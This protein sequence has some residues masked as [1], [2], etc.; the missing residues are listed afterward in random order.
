MLTCPKVYIILVNYK[1]W[2]D[3]AEC[4]ESL[5][6]LDYQNFKVIVVDNDS[7]NG[8]FAQ[9]RSWAAGDSPV[10]FNEQFYAA[11]PVASYPI[12]KPVP[13]LH[14]DSE[15]INGAA[16]ADEK[17]LLVESRKN[18]GFAGGNN[19]GCRLALAHQA[20]YVW[21]LNN[22]TVVEKESLTHLVAHF[23]KSKYNR[24]R[25]GILGAKLLYYHN[26]NFVQAILGKYKPLTASTTHIGLNRPASTPFHDLRI[27]ADDYVVGASMFVSAD[28]VKEVGFMCEEY[29][30]YFEEIDWVKRGA[31]K[32]YTIGV[33]LEAN[34]YHKEGASIGGS[35]K[36]NNN[37]SELS[38]FYSIRNRLI[39]TKKFYP[40]FLYPVYLSLVAV[41]AN[42]VRRKQFDRIPLILKALKSSKKS[43]L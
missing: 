24:Q 2:Q 41:A 21:L 27:E 36:D 43:T 31:A 30:L 8:S 19:V 20:D 5:F 14:F 39:I 26:P 3:T 10:L 40:R 42:R 6:K 22:D 33:C 23:E 16:L 4:L 29:F 13:Y 18:L 7:Q 17:L 9:L 11:T 34:I 32:N 37:K 38:D 1:N 12:S 35:I 28:F 25:L 15:S